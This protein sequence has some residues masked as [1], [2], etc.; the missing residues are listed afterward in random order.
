VGGLN[1]FLFDLVTLGVVVPEEVVLRLLSGGDY[2]VAHVAAIFDTRV[3]ALH[4]LLSHRHRTHKLRRNLRPARVVQPCPDDRSELVG[5]IRLHLRAQLD[6]FEQARLDL[7]TL[8][9][10]AD[11]LKVRLRV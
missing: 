11:R 3:H 4:P 6:R 7:G 5:S 9:E 10:V 8:S 2:Q 1:S